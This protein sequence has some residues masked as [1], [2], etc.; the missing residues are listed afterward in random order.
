MESYTMGS[1][2]EEGDRG[3]GDLVSFTQYKYF[4]A[5]LYCYEY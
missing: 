3:V 5:H 2:F 1:F 4:E